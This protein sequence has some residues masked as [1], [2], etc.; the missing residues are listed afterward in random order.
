[1]KGSIF[2]ENIKKCDRIKPEPC[3]WKNKIFTTLQKCNF[4]K[5]PLSILATFIMALKLH[6]EVKNY[7]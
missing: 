3:V 5:N 7:I 4:C 1:M 6:T 2:I